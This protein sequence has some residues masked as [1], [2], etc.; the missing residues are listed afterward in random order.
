MPGVR[1]I[2]ASEDATIAT[3][4]QTGVVTGV[5]VGSVLIAAS[6]RGQDAFARLTITPA[7]VANVRLSTANQAMFVGDTVRLS[8]Q[9][10]DG[11]G[12]VLGRPVTWSTSTETVASVTGNGLVSAISPG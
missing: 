4:S 12:N 5:R 2:W 11:V 6:A 1:V 9:T 7:P 10:L 8:S 3:V